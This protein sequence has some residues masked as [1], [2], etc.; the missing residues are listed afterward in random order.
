MS[1]CSRRCSTFL[2]IY[3]QRGS[4]PHQRNSLQHGVA[5]LVCVRLFQVRTH[6]AP[7]KTIGATLCSIP[8]FDVGATQCCSSGMVCSCWVATAW[9]HCWSQLPRSLQ[10]PA[11]CIREEGGP[12]A[13]EDVCAN[14]RFLVSADPPAE[15]RRL[16]RL[17]AERRPS[18]RARRLLGRV[19]ARAVAHPPAR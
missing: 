8:V 17:G 19:R 13:G 7:N 18:G 6:L 16:A 15:A 5:F 10:L 1:C 2:S 3:C 12:G 14:V 4:L 11:G 9:R